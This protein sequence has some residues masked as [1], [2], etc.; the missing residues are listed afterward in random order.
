MGNGVKESA[1]RVR[2][3]AEAVLPSPVNSKILELITARAS[4]GGGGS[5]VGCALSCQFSSLKLISDSTL[6]L[7]KRLCGHWTHDGLPCAPL[8]PGPNRAVTLGQLCRLQPS[9]RNRRKMFLLERPQASSQLPPVWGPG[10]CS[11][12]NGGSSPGPNQNHLPSVFK[13]IFCQ[14]GLPAP[15]FH[16]P[17]RG[18][19]Q[20]V[21]RELGHHG[22][23]GALRRHPV[24]R[25]R[26]VQA[27]P[28]PLLWLPRRSPAPL[29]PP[30]GR[31]TSWNN[32]C[33]ADLPP[34]PGQSKDGRDPKGNVQ[35]HLSRLHPHLPR[36]GP[37]DPLPRVH[38]HC[39][40]G[41]SLRRPEFLHL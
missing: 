41:H 35:Q 2:E 37:E 38:A 26:G 18:L 1:V 30:P 14:G 25:P 4:C 31:R 40:G 6:Q 34:G 22:A 33:F 13:K 28:G 21:A 3:D 5:H 32:S 11:G 15:L 10:W 39:A 36:R 12:Q 24:Q 9:T 7:K 8:C 29:A 19:P 27:H 20:P 23:R 17:Q 16:L